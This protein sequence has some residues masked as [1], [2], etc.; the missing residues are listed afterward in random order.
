VPRWEHAIAQLG[1]FVYSIV[2]WNIKV[3][4]F[5]VYRFLGISLIRPYFV[6][7]RRSTLIEVW[8]E[9]AIVF[10]DYYRR[11]HG[12]L[13]S[14]KT[15]SL[16]MGV[17]K[18]S[19]RAYGITLTTL[20]DTYRRYRETGKILL[21]RSKGKYRLLRKDDIRKIAESILARTFG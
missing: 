15:I 6:K 7:P 9:R 3:G 8:L 1:D 14:L 16:E 4:Y 13:P 12:K 2:K 21:V 5:N 19:L 11:L 20:Y 17:S 18:S 10:I